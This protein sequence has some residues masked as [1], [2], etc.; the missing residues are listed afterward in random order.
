MP[1][2]PLSWLFI[3]IVLT[4]CQL[5]VYLHLLPYLFRIHW[6]FVLH[7]SDNILTTLKCPC[8][9]TGNVLYRQ[10]MGICPMVIALNY[11]TF[12]IFG[13]VLL[14]CVCICFIC[15]HTSKLIFF[16]PLYV[17]HTREKF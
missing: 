15:M 13:N 14:S 7:S 1:Y 10:D 8:V 11:A 2:L 3:S 5:L 9:M 17:H 4:V 16:S 12:L 6:Y